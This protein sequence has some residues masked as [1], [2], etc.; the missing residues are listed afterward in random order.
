MNKPYF[1]IP[2][3]IFILLFAIGTQA[4]ETV[5]SCGGNATAGGASISYTVG[6]AVFTTQTNA[7]GTVAPGVQQPYEIL[8]VIG[9]DKANGIK[10]EFSVYPNPTTDFL[11]LQVENYDLENLSCQLYDI[12]GIVILNNEIASKETILVTD[13]LPHGTYF[14]RIIEYGKEIKIF[15]IIKN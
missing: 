10:L 15:K 8:I 2:I 13:Y 11:M 9:I 12:N 4:Q 3:V 14:L 5:T 6:Q 7:S 1:T